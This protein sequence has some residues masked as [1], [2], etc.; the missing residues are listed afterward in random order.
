MSATALQGLPCSASVGR[1]ASSSSCPAAP[2][3][4]P[5]APTSMYVLKGIGQCRVCLHASCFQC[6]VVPTSL[7][8][9]S[10]R[11]T[12]THYVPCLG[13][14]CF[15][16]VHTPNSPFDWAR[17][18]RTPPRASPRH[19]SPSCSTPRR[20][21]PLPSPSCPAPL[22]FPTPGPLGSAR[23]AVL[24]AAGANAEPLRE[25]PGC[26]LGHARR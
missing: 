5:S 17:L 11:I 20:P 12:W 19:P 2:S 10:G 1:S 3:L 25:R 7:L 9:S 6:L 15:Q 18:R 16:S 24:Q 26:V 22:L 21:A 13:P 23:V 4:C 14:Q 8:T